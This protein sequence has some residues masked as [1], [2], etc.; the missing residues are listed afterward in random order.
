M[1]SIRIKDKK[2][3]EENCIKKSFV[4]RIYHIRN[5][6]WRRKLAGQ[7]A[8]MWLWEVYAIYLLLTQ[9]VLYYFGVTV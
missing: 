8:R 2:N 4:I 1:G 9:K 5:I 6:K 3:S 7:L